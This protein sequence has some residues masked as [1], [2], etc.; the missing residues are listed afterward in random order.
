MSF[1]VFFLTN[2]LKTMSFRGVLLLYLMTYLAVNKKIGRYFFRLPPLS[3]MGGK[4]GLRCKL[5]INKGASIMNILKDE[6]IID[7]GDLIKLHLKNYYPPLSK[8]LYIAIEK[9]ISIY[10]VQEEFATSN[11]ELGSLFGYKIRRVKEV[12][13]EL[14]ALGIITKRHGIYFNGSRLTNN[15]LYITINLPKLFNP[16]NFSQGKITLMPRNKSTL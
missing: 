1:S 14:T 16:P 9:L 12:T 13:R 2:Q 3:I 6:L 15:T 8:H 10:K 7:L 5:S 11:E 4:S